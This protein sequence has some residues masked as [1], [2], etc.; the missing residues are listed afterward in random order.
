MT[1]GDSEYSAD[2]LAHQE[3]E[4]IKITPVNAGETKRVQSIDFIRG[5]VMIIMALDH[6]RDYFHISAQTG[7]PTDLTSTTPA[8]FFTRWITH[9]C[10]PAFIFL[11]GISV[12]ISS[13]N[14]PV[15]R[16]SYFLIKRGLW[17]VFADAII[18][19]FALT[20]NPYY[21]FVFLTVLWAIGCSMIL[22]GM[23]MRFAPRS[24][25][26]LG[27][28]IFLGHDLLSLRN[29]PQEST[30]TDLF[31]IFFTGI[32]I[33]PI[34]KS[35]LLG[36]F[37]AILPWTSVMF[38]GY[39]FGKHIDDKKKVMLTGFGLLSL[40]IILRMVNVYGEPFPRQMQQTAFYTFLSFINTTKYP[41]SLQF[42]CMTLG[43]MLILQSG[44]RIRNTPAQNFVMTYGRV[45]FF[46]FV[47]H[48]F[49]AHILLVFAFY[50][51]GHTNA[52][53]VDSKS[54][55]FFRPFNFGFSLP[56]V[57][58]VWIIVVLMLY[59]PSRWFYQ[60]K[61]ANKKWWLRYL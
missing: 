43:S 45:P 61:L 5:I 25:L 1:T 10:A 21:N 32:F 54:P 28:L 15:N 16:V 60:Y 6:V 12:Y 36:F 14:K 13:K 42:L 49:V 40:F 56:V 41:P 8:L 7:N 27:L 30:W 11:S 37:Y 31:K 52:E 34:G 24:I 59:Y 23:A 26:P 18:M 44:I 38:L 50:V 35:H 2:T 53:I 20:F 39:W 17:L 47:V 29:I 22:L 48:F 58:L 46:Y 33:T 19:T 51:T 55:F 57:Y 9:F 3:N 4:P